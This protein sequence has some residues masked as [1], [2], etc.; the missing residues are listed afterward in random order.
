[1]HSASQTRK[2]WLKDTFG[3]NPARR[4]RMSRN[5]KGSMVSKTN[6]KTNGSVVVWD[7]CWCFVRWGTR[8]C[9]TRSNIRKGRFKRTPL[10]HLDS[11]QPNVTECLEIL[12]LDGFYN[13]RKSGQLCGSIGDVYVF[14][15]VVELRFADGFALCEV[16]CTKM[17]HGIKCTKR[18][19]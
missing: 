5:P 9:P 16:E 14:C 15:E 7:I 18:L 19:I 17:P 13:H 12:R 8:K 10:L 11:S 4:S 2:G 6:A 1:M 3:F